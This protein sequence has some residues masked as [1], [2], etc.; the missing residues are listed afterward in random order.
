MISPLRSDMLSP[1]S[2][3]LPDAR[4]AAGHEKAAAGGDALSIRRFLSD[5]AVS[6]GGAIG[7]LL[8]VPRL[9]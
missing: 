6:D 8:S 4:C 1:P 7:T 5:I 3:F 2:I 9:Q